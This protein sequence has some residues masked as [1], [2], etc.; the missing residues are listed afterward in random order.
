MVCLLAMYSPAPLKHTHGYGLFVLCGNIEFFQ[1]RFPNLGLFCD[2]FISEIT[3]G[4]TFGFV[5]I[6]L[7]T[8]LDISNAC[9]ILY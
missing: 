2:T 5:R 9:Q 3:S 6:L 4:D 8:I 1:V 7:F